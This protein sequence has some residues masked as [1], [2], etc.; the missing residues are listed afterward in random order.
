[1]TNLNSNEMVL[2]G[3]IGGTK[4]NL[5]FYSK[6]KTRP[7][8]KV[9]ETFS[10]RNAPTLEGI[11]ER[12]I[13]R[14]ALSFSRACFAIAGPVIN[15][16]CKTTNLPW[17]VS[18]AQITQRFG[19]PARLINDLAATGVG[20]PLLYTRELH[21]LNR[22][23]A[24]KGH[25]IA[26]VAP[27]T[28]LGTSTLTYHDGNYISIASEGG[29]V[30]FSPTNEDQVLLW[31]Y[32]YQRYG[33]VSIERVVSGVG[34][35]NIFS[36]LRKTGDYEIPEWLSRDLVEKDPGEVITGAALDKGVPICQKILSIFTSVLGSVAGNMAL[37][38]LATGGVY[39]GGGIPP[40]ILPAL[41]DG[42]FMDAFTYKGRFKDLLENI[43]VK[44]ILNDK[45]ALLGAARWGLEGD[46]E[47]SQIICRRRKTAPSP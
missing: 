43:P 37:T 2:A 29:H 20:I 32:L 44:V 40:K 5:A 36:C 28:G 33:H 1:M 3:D 46:L 22:A 16:R 23:K 42:V 7:V 18:E 12:F 4:T 24:R 34:F 10:S 47:V 8:L 35:L 31:R 6:G 17:D 19:R 9:M 27:G 13:K 15:K 25:T 11:I 45:T 39:L 26:L 14:H 38:V 30:D 41:S 21:P